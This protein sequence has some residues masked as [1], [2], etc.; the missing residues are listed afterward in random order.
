M[1]VNLENCRATFS[2]GG[3]SLS[4][5]S[6]AENVWRLQSERNGRFEDGAAQILAED[7]GETPDRT[8]RPLTVSGGKISADD[9]AYVSVTDR[10]IAFHDKHGELRRTVQAI[11][12]IKSGVELTLTLGE[13]ERVY[14]TG[15]R[16]NRVNQRGKKVR[17]YAVDRWC[18][19]EGNSYM[20]IPF[21]TTSDCTG[22]FL[23][24][25]ERATFDIGKTAKNK[26]QLRQYY[27][28]VDLY[29]FTCD[30]P[31][32]VLLAYSR[33]TGFAPLPPAW[34]FGTLVCRY[35]PEFGSPEGILAMTREMEK[36]DFPWEAVIVEG[37][38]T[39][40]KDR[41]GELKNVSR[42]VHALG[43]KL[44]VY[45]Q[46]GRFPKNAAD[47]GLE[48]RFAVHTAA[49]VNLNETKSLN[50]LDNKKRE[51]MRCVDITDPA[52]VEK[53]QEIWG[54]LQN[55]VGVDGA[56]IDFCE[57]FPDRPDLRFADGRDPMGAHHWYPTLYNVQ[58]YKHFNTRPD[59]GLCFSRGGGIGAQRYPFVWAGDQ[60]REF[61]FLKVV[62]KAALSLGF[63][64]VPFASWDM[65]GYQP[66]WN[67]CDKRNE[68]KVFIRGLEFTAFSPC[69]QTHGKVKRPYDFD[70]HTRA[71]YR[72]YAHLHDG[73]RPYLLEQAKV[74]TETGLPLMRHLFFHDP[75]D[76][77]A[78][79]IED[80]YLLGCGLLVAP[81]LKNAGRR[82][83]Y[84]PR[85]MWTEIFTG[86]TYEGRQWVRG[87]NAPLER[88]AVFALQN[89]PSEALAPTLDALKERL[90]Q[91]RGLWTKTK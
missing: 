14:G 51:D 6:P 46:C 76:G 85:G 31:A 70:E 67:Q 62:I 3:F 48:D 8:L 7:V 23:N 18:Q 16:F 40:E 83:V 66:A 13:N 89:A 77:I 19:T 12:P 69:I 28:P 71:V 61:R 56:K 53:W 65:A 30:T 5:T 25:Y 87:M 39:F 68:N 58:R 80:E 60:L 49:G 11:T 64:G 22:L 90:A 81:V 44:M 42:Q 91:I 75:S 2:L 78:R 38:R 29:V 9:G 86:E 27:A 72:A 10:A 63:S 26:L 73:L 57:Q 37:W 33:L 35:H 34:A 15:E 74:A 4:V 20:P 84:L 32:E 21:I 54:E 59:G 1:K 41:W 43:K 17:L 50:L 24:R 52:S 36:N 82:D 79:D 47:F 88:I 55:D 45:E